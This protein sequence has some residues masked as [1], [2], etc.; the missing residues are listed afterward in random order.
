MGKKFK[1]LLLK[2]NDINAKTVWLLLVIYLKTKQNDQIM[3]FYPETDVWPANEKSAQLNFV[4]LTKTKGHLCINWIW[5]P[6]TLSVWMT[7]TNSHLCVMIWVMIATCL[8]STNLICVSYWSMVPTWKR[9]VYELFICLLPLDISASVAV[10]V[11][12]ERDRVWRVQQPHFTAGT[13]FLHCYTAPSLTAGQAW[14][15]L[16]PP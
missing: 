13:L 7:K 16:T 1:K 3:W 15:R 5:R 14:A 8:N 6:A 10:G 9:E 2:K 11:Q 4:D 12:I